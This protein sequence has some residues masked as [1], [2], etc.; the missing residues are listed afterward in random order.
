MMKFLFAFLLLL[1]VPAPVAI[2]RNA[3]MPVV[4]KHGMVVTAQHVASK[5]GVNILKQGGNAV[6]AAVAVGYALAVVD[7]CCGNLGGGGFMLIRLANGKKAFLN[8]REKAPL[9]ASAKMY[10]NRQGE[11]V[12]GESTKSW[13]SIGVPGT[14][15]GLDTALK[16]YGTM[17]L[18]QVMAPAI[19][20]AE[21]GFVLNEGDV[22]IL[23]TRTKTFARQANV[24]SIF[25][26][27]GKP[28]QVGD[29]LVQKKLA[30]TLKRIGKNGTR[31]FYRGPIAAAIVKASDRHGGIL[32]LKDFKDY[33]VE[34][35]KP[36]H[37]RYRGFDVFSAPPPSSGGTTM[38]EIL[39]IVGGYPLSKFGFHSVNSV[40]FLAEAMRYSY[41]DRNTK[42]GDPDFVDNPIAKLLSPR[43]ARKI[44]DKINPKKPTPSSKLDGGPGL[45]EGDDTTHYSIVD[46]NGNAVAVTYTINWYFGSG[47]I[48]GD[49]GFFLNNEMDDFTAKPGVPNSFGLVQGKANAIAPGKRPL[50]SM[51]PTIVTHGGKLFMVT[52]SPGGSRIITITLESILNVIDYGMNVQQAID[53]PRIHQQW[54][55]DVVQLEPHALK[56]AVR[57]TLER[58]GYRFKT[59]HRWGAAEAIVIDPQTG[60]LK[61]ASDPREPAGSADGY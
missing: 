41:A 7:P 57:A 46:A 34:W 2:A 8:F 3:P 35:E 47:H 54:L 10:Q 13:K 40:H 12:R 37:C 27:D 45:P 49:T 55:P 42:L 58:R 38:C 50:S 44:R 25:L 4:A 11:V 39:N 52:G 17:S 61:G 29:R 33:S 9:A 19:R 23:H 21:K 56:S 1:T 14:V 20:L 24:A 22:A 26:K 60:K 51:S 36:I 28:Y 16:K 31:A 5:V 48:A 18:K 30:R 32:S 6:D 59:H 53:A 43:H 15:M